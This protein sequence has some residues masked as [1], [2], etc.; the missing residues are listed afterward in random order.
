MV[1]DDADVRPSRRKFFRSSGIG[2]GSGRGRYGAG[3]ARERAGHKASVYRYRAAGALNGRQLA[4]EARKRRSDI[5]V[6]FTSG[7]AHNAIV[8]H[9]RFGPGVQ[10]IVKPFNFDAV[11]AKIR[12]MLDE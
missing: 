6:L 7:Y 10:L 1:E 2:I 12:Q 9:G 8:H 5:K 3:L 4:D 11:A